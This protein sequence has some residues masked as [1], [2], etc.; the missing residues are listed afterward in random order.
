MLSTDTCLPSPTTNPTELFPTGKPFVPTVVLPVTV[1]LTTSVSVLLKSPPAAKTY[2][3]TTTV[4]LSAALPFVFILCVLVLGISMMCVLY[5]RRKARLGHS[6]K[7]QNPRVFNESLLEPQTDLE[8]ATLPPRVVGS[9]IQPYQIVATQLY[10]SPYRILPT[11]IL[12]PLLIQ[13][14]SEPENHLSNAL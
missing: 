3:S 4:A 5:K 7:K 10:I 11:A 14:L 12:F 2:S 1:S 9:Y 8:P 6:G 13:I